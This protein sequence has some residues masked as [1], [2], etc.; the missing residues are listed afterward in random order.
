VA[1][2]ETATVLNDVHAVAAIVDYSYGHIPS[3]VSCPLIR[4]R[5]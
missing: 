3:D 5:F 1:D 2:A 4:W